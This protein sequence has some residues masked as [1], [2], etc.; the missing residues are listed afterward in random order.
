MNNETSTK[1]TLFLSEQ[2]TAELKSIKN[3]LFFC[4]IVNSLLCVGL[5][6][7]LFCLIRYNFF[8]KKL[9]LTKKSVFKPKNA[10]IV[11]AIMSPIA[12]LLR[13]LLTQMII[14]VGNHPH[15]FDLS[16]CEVTMDISL[17]LYCF[18]L[19]PV[20]FF[21]WCRQ[22]VIYSK[23]T[24]KN[25][26][27]T[28]VKVL[29]KTFVLLFLVGGIFS[30][31]VAVEPKTYMNSPNNR[32]IGCVLYKKNETNITS[33]RHFS[34]YMAAAIVITSQFLLLGLLLN[35]LIKQSNF[36]CKND[37]IKNKCHRQ[38]LRVIKKASVCTIA[39]IL[40]Q[41]VATALTTSNVVPQSYPRVFSFFIY[42]VSLF[43]QVNCVVMC[44][45][46][47]ATILRGK[48]VRK[49]NSLSETSTAST[50]RF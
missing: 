31:Y 46:S 50:A 23:P 47:P 13:S 36:S 33:V 29:S 6:W 10:M 34:N 37:N 7:L 48:K 42:D 15:Y 39:C 24:M 41:I 43:V 4:Q 32:S 12:A 16:A 26:K 14:F 19:L 35:P 40:T 38:L 9:K 44:F 20:Y 25:F 17:V 28:L 5:L 18:T 8:R 49:I 22:K 2:K 21:I 45:E 1:S 11:L 3:W 27:T 30:L